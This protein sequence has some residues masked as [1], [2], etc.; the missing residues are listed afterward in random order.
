MDLLNS[1]LKEYKIWLD[2]TKE[3]K[4]IQEELSALENAPEELLECFGGD[5]S[6]GT[7]GI[8]GLLGPG[9]RRINSYVVARAT[10][11]LSDYINSLRSKGEAK[12]RVVV[13]YD[14][15]LFS[16]EFA[17]RTAEVL[18]GNGI[19]AFVFSETTP[20]S[21]LSYSIGELDCDYGIMITASHNAGVFNGYKVYNRYGYQIVG[22]E[23]KEILDAINSHDFFSNI[24]SSNDNITYLDS[25][26][27][28]SFLNKAH[29]VVSEFM[30]IEGKEELSIVYTPLNGTGRD[31]VKELLDKEGFTQVHSVPVQD[32]PDHNFTTCKAPNPE[33]LSA[34]SEA[35]RKLDEVEGDIIIATDPDSD[36]MGV[37]LVHEGT[38]INLTGNQIAL[39]MLD[40]LC[41]I[42]APKSGQKIYR[43]VV[44]SP[45][46]DR[47][48]ESY[49]LEVETTLIGFKHIG[50]AIE[51]MMTI[52]EMDKFYFGAE[53]SNGFLIDPFLRDKDGITSSAIIAAVAALQK[54][55]GLDLV[56]KLNE[57]YD[58]FGALI[59]KSKSFTFQGLSGEETIGEIMHYLRNEMSDQ[60]GDLYI[61][62]KTDYLQD[63]T[64]LSPSNII[65][66]DMD[67][68]STAIIRPSGTEPKVKVY[69]FLTD[70]ISSIDKGITELMERF[71]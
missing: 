25:K 40:F 5:L 3:D 58:D 44:T 61:E 24:K 34:Y 46:L 54:K 26:L 53:E 23:P 14:T 56:D 55:N 60:I 50:K 21:V 68:G 71:K 7:S 13:G 49:G 62:D 8:R 36:R 52:D 1:A 66:F 42:K 2:N 32:K 12:G 47:V 16:K 41:S 51:N 69:M 18:S 31:Y 19:E 39:L 43:S 10:Q 38:K 64:G 35:F 33:K 63:D 28:E 37:A 17:L 59:D 30:N 45:L 27:K 11:G 9:P 70:P 48:A 20:V 29:E 6:F 22:E 65:R 57:I 15:R 4:H 67:D